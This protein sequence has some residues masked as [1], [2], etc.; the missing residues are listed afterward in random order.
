MSKYANVVAEVEKEFD[1]EVDDEFIKDVEAHIKN[2]KRCCF[3]CARKKLVPDLIKSA[4]RCVTEDEIGVIGCSIIDISGLE[5]IVLA[6]L[7]PEALDLSHLDPNSATISHDVAAIVRSSEGLRGEE[8]ARRVAGL[9]S[10]LK[11]GK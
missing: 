9:V 1:I 3:V 5:Q 8:L 2:A 4:I 6:L 11:A 7:V 10:D